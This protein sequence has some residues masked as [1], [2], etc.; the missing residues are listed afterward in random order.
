MSSQ[1][2]KPSKRRTFRGTFVTGLL[3]ILPVYVTFWVIRFFFRQ[4][5]GAVTPGIL[6]L[7]QLAGLG[8]LLEA[9]W[10]NYIAPLISIILLVFFITLLGLIGG[11]V[12]GRQ[13]LGA[14][15]RVLRTIPLVRGI[16]TATRQFIDTFSSES[17]SF[18]DVVLVE[19]PR[20]G[21]WTLALLTGDTQGEVQRKTGRDVVSVFVPTTPNPTSGWLLF[22]P[23][24]EIIILEM[25]IDDAF[26]M[27]I[28][29]GVLTPPYHGMEAAKNPSVV[30]GA[31]SEW[32]ESA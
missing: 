4:I 15:D 8:W 3:I 31:E 17:R 6:K 12:L 7:M 27:I 21:L 16:Y 18:R 28:S 25:S 24:D 32:V 23:K 2:E 11:N 19:Y 20:Q 5:D 9:G 29:G 1:I 22:V 26:K 10:V 14:I 13:V 30:P